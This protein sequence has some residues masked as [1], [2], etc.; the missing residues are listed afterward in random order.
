MINVKH[1]DPKNN[2]EVALSRPNGAAAK[3]RAETRIYSRRSPAVSAAGWPA[4]RAGQTVAEKPQPRW[5]GAKR[6]RHLVIERQ[7]CRVVCMLAKIQY[8][9]AILARDWLDHF[10]TPILSLHFPRG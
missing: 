4:R 1:D 9:Q 3:R 7:I 8:I 5:R 10:S 2:E 6:P